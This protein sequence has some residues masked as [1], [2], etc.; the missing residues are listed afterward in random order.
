MKQGNSIKGDNGGGD[1]RTGD[2]T[3]KRACRGIGYDDTR[4]RHFPAIRN[5][6]F[7]VTSIHFRALDN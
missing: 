5:P 3:G 6:A 1:E 2:I 7:H 4:T